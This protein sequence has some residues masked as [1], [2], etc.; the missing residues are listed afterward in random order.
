[1]FAAWYCK[2]CLTLTF[3]PMSAGQARHLLL[4]QVLW[5]PRIASRTLCLAR[6]RCALLCAEL[7]FGVKLS[8]VSELDAKEFR[9]LLRSV[10][11]RFVRSKQLACSLVVQRFRCLI[12]YKYS[13][14]GDR[15]CLEGH[16]MLPLSS[17]LLNLSLFII[18]KI[19]HANKNRC[20][21]KS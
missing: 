8:F 16:C 2:R 11:I 6:L 4:A 1:M 13:R 15:C 3:E 18:V 21:E 17:Q 10:E 19:F 7:K 14:D 20:F 12:S 5:S 9:A